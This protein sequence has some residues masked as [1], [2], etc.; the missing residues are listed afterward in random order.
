MSEQHRLECQNGIVTGVWW[1]RR[2]LRLESA[3]HP[4]DFLHVAT[5]GWLARVG[6]LLDFVDPD[7]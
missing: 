1:D 7:T 6:F 3:C 5:A 4:L 2:P